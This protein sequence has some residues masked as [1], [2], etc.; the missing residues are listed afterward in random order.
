MTQAVIK[1]S[2]FITI[3]WNNVTEKAEEK[4]FVGSNSENELGLQD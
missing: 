2:N 1:Q 4:D 3:V